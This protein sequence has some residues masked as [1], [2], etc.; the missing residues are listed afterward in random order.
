MIAA[1]LL[2]LSSIAHG[3]RAGDAMVKRAPLDALYA[4]TVHPGKYV[5]LAAGDVASVEE[6][7][8]AIATPHDREPGS[9]L[10]SLFLPAIDPRVVAAIGGE[11]QTE[12]AGEALGI[13]ELTTVAAT[14]A[15]SRSGRQGRRRGIAGPC[16]SPMVWGGKPMP[17]SKA[18]WPRS[19][20]RWPLRSRASRDRNIESPMS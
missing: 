4:G 2:E 5:L 13:V 9:V 3:I 17:C 19:K 10:D 11:H 1:G 6:A 18:W 16:I 14:I 20:P 12:H 8:A 7:M 15:A